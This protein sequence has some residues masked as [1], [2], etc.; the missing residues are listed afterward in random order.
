MSK[1]LQRKTIQGK[2]TFKENGVQTGTP[3]SLPKEVTVTK[4]F[5]PFQAASNLIGMATANPL[6]KMGIDAIADVCDDNPIQN[7][8]QKMKKVDNNPV[9]NTI[10]EQVQNVQKHVQQIVQ[11]SMKLNRDLNAN[12]AAK[13]NNLNLSIGPSIDIQS[14]NPSKTEV[15]EKTRWIPIVTRE[16]LIDLDT[17]K[18]TKTNSRSRVGPLRSISGKIDPSKVALSKRLQSKREHIMMERN[19]NPIFSVPKANNVCTVPPNK[20]APQ[21]G[22]PKVSMFDPDTIPPPELESFNPYKDL[23]SNQ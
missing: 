7:P 1:R 17:N 11:Q 23:K 18:G 14:N 4:A 9:K 6:V 10:D 8:V 12:H 22:Q 5:S 15:R 2:Q 20:I 21:N 13:V 19:I 16:N 3:R